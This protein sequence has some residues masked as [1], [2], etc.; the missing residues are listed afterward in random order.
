MLNP[1]LWPMV[2]RNACLRRYYETVLKCRKLTEA[3]SQQ[4]LLDTQA[5][6]GLLLEFPACGEPAAQLQTRPVLAWSL[7]CWLPV[8]VLGGDGC[9]LAMQPVYVCARLQGCIARGGLSS[10]RPILASTAPDLM[11]RRPTSSG[12][13]ASRDSPTAAVRMRTH[14]PP[15]FSMR[16]GKG[17]QGAT[18]GMAS[19]VNLDLSRC[20]ALLKIT[21]LLISN[22]AYVCMPRQQILGCVC[23]QGRAGGARRHGQR[24]QPGPGPLRGAAQGRRQPPRALGAQLLHPAS[25]R[26][27]GRLPTHPGHQGPH[28]C[29][30]PTAP[31]W[32]CWLLLSYSAF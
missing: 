31:V 18:E 7:P 20:K 19:V 13:L 1:R 32:G 30:C 2:S 3:G 26:Q 5:I 27:P 25:L 12:S 16:A 14:S 22:C 10:S 21:D 29:L 28:L 15:T 6:R 24:R 11:Q 23:R 4:L 8:S 17:A 9:G